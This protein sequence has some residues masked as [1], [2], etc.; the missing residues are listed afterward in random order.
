[1]WDC[2][3]DDYPTLENPLFGAIKLVKN[4]DIGRYKYSGYGIGFDRHGTF[5]VANG[6]GKNKII[7]G[8]D[9]SSSVPVYNKK[10]DTL[11]LGEGVKVLHKD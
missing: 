5:S 1:M 11:I 4:A 9:I 7:F 2:G 3:Y 6:F 8:A 10:K